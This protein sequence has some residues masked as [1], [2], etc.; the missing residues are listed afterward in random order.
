LSARAQTQLDAEV[1]FE[2]ARR[3][4]SMT[5]GELTRLLADDPREAALWID[6]AAR[7][8]VTEAQLNMGQ[9]LLD[10]VGVDPDPEKALAWFR[11]AADR[12]SAPA[13]NM[14]GRCL[15]NGWGAPIDLALA[16]DWY[17][18]S[19]RAGHDWGQYNYAHMLFDGRGVPRDQAQAVVWYE[20]AARQG[21]A[22]AMNLL[23]RCLEEGWGVRREPRRAAVWYQRSAE[24]G[25]FRAQFNHAS[26]LASLGEMDEALMWFERALAGAQGPSLAAMA[27]ALIR[28]PDPRLSALGGQALA[29]K[30]ERQRDGQGAMA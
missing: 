16:A 17:H 27:E 7:H 3:L 21:H 18:R 5:S 29:A 25:Y 2:R 4:R 6:S 30:P 20:R 22:R 8:G 24:A 28:Q 23:A 11:W 1:S 13:M 9:R 26:L 19:A 15:E 10:G 12:G 14:V